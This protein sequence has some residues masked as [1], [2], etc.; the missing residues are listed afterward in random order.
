M[1]SDQQA[2]MKLLRLSVLR[3]FPAEPEAQREL[4]AVLR[5][6]ENEAHADR[7]VSWWL[8]NSTYS[9]APADLRQA[10]SETAPPPI[11]PDPNCR[12][13][14]GS[15][16]RTGWYRVSYQGERRRYE[17]ISAADARKQ[18]GIEVIS[19]ATYCRDCAYGRRLA[20]AAE[21]ARAQKAPER[22]QGQLT[23]AK[24]AKGV[25]DGKSC[26][27]PVSDRG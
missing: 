26:A 12:T 18:P 3:G 4:M 21:A 11:Q 8:E 19:A 13:C 16:W 22:R 6:A 5:D 20:A 23:Q 17:P 9:P 2:A 27:L 1:I 15:G 7:A 25:M 14:N 24:Q 10:L